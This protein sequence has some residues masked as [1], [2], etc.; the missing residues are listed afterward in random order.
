M[1]YVC[2]LTAG[3]N[4]LPTN[5]TSR[6]YCHDRRWFNLDTT[7]LW[8]GMGQAKSATAMRLQQELDSHHETKRLLTEGATG[9]CDFIPR[10]KRVDLEGALALLA[11]SRRPTWHI[12]QP[13]RTSWRLRRRS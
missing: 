12:M 7:C 1:W 10:L 11:D 4:M 13:S 8:P 5:S 9:F 3:L 2:D 6:M